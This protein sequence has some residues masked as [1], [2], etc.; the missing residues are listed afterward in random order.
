M[1]KWVAIVLLLTACAPGHKPSAT[2]PDQ[3]LGEELFFADLNAQ[4]LSKRCVGCH[5]PKEGDPKRPAGGVD[6]TSYEKIMGQAELV[7]AGDPSRSL[8][9]KM[10]AEG[11]MPPKRKL[12]AES[13]QLIEEWILQGA[14]E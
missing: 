14:R 12:E 4:V 5:S 3:K 2:S 11:K 1:K 8:L 10:V 13:V 6:L 7:F 9:Y